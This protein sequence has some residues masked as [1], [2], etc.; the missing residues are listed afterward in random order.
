[1]KSYKP[2]NKHYMGIC[3]LTETLQTQSLKNRRMGDRNSKDPI[4]ALKLMFNRKSFDLVG[5]RAQ[6]IKVIAIK[7]DH[8]SSTPQTHIVERDSLKLSPV[9]HKGTMATAHTHT[10]LLFSP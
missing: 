4:W 9:L 1:M 10:H 6:L 8:P 2:L 3:G 7:P 5:K